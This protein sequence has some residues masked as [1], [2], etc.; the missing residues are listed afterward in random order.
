MTY[1]TKPQR[2]T[3]PTNKFKQKQFVATALTWKL[4]YS[5]HAMLH[6]T[7]QHGNSTG[8]NLLTMDGRTTGRNYH[9]ILHRPTNSTETACRYHSDPVINNIQVLPAVPHTMIRCGNSTQKFFLDDRRTTYWTKPRR[10]TAPTDKF[11]QKQ[12][13][14]TALTQKLIYTLHAVPH[15]TNRH[16]N[17]T[18]R[19]L[20]T[21]RRFGHVE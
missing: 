19:N 3:A 5:L 18:R 6:M 8:R 15:M 11:K 14:A 2:N 13:V 4:I 1:W 20:L 21:T 10:N 7:N 17:L 16:G 12:L 9:E